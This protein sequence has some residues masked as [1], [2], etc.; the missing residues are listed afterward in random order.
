[1]SLTDACCFGCVVPFERIAKRIKSAMCEVRKSAFYGALFAW[2]TEGHFQCL[3][4][5]VEVLHGIWLR[6]SDHERL[7]PQESGISNE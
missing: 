7:E 6:E 1:V 4:E 3:A 5:E 2:V